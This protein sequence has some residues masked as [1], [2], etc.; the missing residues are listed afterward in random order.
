[1]V[2]KTP[3]GCTNNCHKFLGVIIP[4]LKSGSGASPM[5]E[6]L[7]SRSALAAQ[8]FASLDPGCGHGTTLQAMLRRRPT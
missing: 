1:M 3:F 5:A 8:G 4:I 6:R 7:S 2:S